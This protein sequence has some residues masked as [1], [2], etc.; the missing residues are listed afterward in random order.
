MAMWA[1]VQNVSRP[2]DMC[3]DMSQIPPTM[4]ETMP[5]TMNQI[6]QGIDIAD[7][8]TYSMGRAWSGN[9]AGMVCDMVTPSRCNQ[10]EPTKSRRGCSLHRDGGWLQG[11][12][13]IGASDFFLKSRIPRERERDPYQLNNL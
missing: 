1:G 7:E 12:R 4:P 3:Q 6:V 11:N 9:P 8:D 13:V 2:I 5:A 10:P